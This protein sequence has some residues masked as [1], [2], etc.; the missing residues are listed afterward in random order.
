MKNKSLMALATVGMVLAYGLTFLF[1]KVALQS[2]TPFVIL[3]LR[4]FFAVVTMLILH[5]LNIVHIELN[6]LTKRDLGWL[7]MVAIPYPVLAM[8]L[9]MLGLQFSTSAMGGIIVALMPVMTSLLGIL[10]LKERPRLI[11]WLFILCS[12]VGVL[13]NALGTGFSVG[14]GGL[15]GILLFLIADT[16]GS[17]NTVLSR[18][19]ARHFSSVTISFVAVCCG[20]VAFT[21]IAVVQGIMGGNL[22]ASYLAAFQSLP[23]LGSILYLGIIASGTGFLCLNY[24]LANMTAMKVSIICNMTSVVGIAAGVLILH[25]PLYLYQVIG[26]LFILAGVIGIN[27]LDSMNAANK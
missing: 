9:E 17:L 5:K 20:T 1:S 7:I 24:M 2:A 16:C 22:A 15:I 27:V 23:A 26:A 10:I 3:S 19:S 25:E 18:Y 4:F 11:Q 6:I 21:L 14:A 8:S 12:V 13:M